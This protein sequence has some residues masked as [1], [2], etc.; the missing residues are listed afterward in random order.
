LARKLS[1]QKSTVEDQKM[2]I[3]AGTMLLSDL[4]EA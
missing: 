1:F 2:L 3:P 4:E